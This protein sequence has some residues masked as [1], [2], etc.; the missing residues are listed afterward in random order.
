MR[1]SLR[2][3]ER[4]CCICRSKGDKRT[5]IRLVA[6]Q[7]RLVVDDLQR[8]PGRGGYVHP[9]VDCV[10]RMGQSQRW[11]R[12]LRVEGASLEASQVSQ[13][14]KELMT[15]VG[16]LVNLSEDGSANRGRTKRVRL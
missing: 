3:I 1:E 4:T 16:G 10:S 7:G 13:V 2:T 12:V 14:V 8:L 6:S 9:T 15:R 5:L 11:E